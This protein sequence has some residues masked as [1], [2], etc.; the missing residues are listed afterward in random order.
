MNVTTPVVG[1][2]VYL[3]IPS[4]TISP[5]LSAPT[6]LY[7]AVSH[8][9]FVPL[10]VLVILFNSVKRARPS[11]DFWTSPWLPVVSSFEDSTP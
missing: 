7:L 5:L 9:T 4:L 8:L 2:I 10:G 6:N 11:L 1:S 3:P